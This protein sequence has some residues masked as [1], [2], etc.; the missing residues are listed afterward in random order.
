MP[1]GV[2]VWVAA[3]AETDAAEIEALAE[4]LPASVEG[5][6]CRLCSGRL[7]AKS[8]II[9][10]AFTNVSIWGLK[11]QHKRRLSSG[12]PP[13]VRNALALAI[14]PVAVSRTRP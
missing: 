7:T 2:G 14:H 5:S 8:R 3:A 12:Q 9:G 1:T 11:P 13:T 10:V 4:S 6:A